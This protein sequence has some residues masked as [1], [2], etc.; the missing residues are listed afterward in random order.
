MTAASKA[1]LRD[2]L[3][4]VHR[5]A[6]GLVDVMVVRLEDAPD[7]MADAA[8]G[9]R[10]ARMLL[11]AVIDALARIDAA[12]RRAP[13]LCV[14]CPR[15]LKRGQFSFG[16][17]MPRCDDPT[18]MIALAVCRRCATDR[19]GIKVRVMVGLQKVWPDLRPVTVTHPAGGRA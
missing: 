6:A 8:A 16:F 1:I 9:D 7:M 3:E 2:G 18:A 4:R 15:A 10:E 17:A 11:T 19:D 13:A 5:E 12:P 14:S